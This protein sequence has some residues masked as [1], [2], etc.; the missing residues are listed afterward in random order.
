[1]EDLKFNLIVFNHF[2]AV[3]IEVLIAVIEVLFAVVK[4][5]VIIASLI[6]VPKK[7]FNL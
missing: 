1:M 4:V 3:V 5:T 6:N 2:I 7:N